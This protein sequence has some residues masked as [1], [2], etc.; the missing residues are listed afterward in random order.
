MKILATIAL[1]VFAVFV[2]GESAVGQSS[3]LAGDWS[4]EA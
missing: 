1:T 4:G 3:G 2:W